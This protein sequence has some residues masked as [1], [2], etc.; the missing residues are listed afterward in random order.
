MLRMLNNRQKWEKTQAYL[1]VALFFGLD[2]CLCQHWSSAW[3]K[4]YL[5]INT[6]LFRTLKHHTH[7]HLGG[8][9]YNQSLSP[10]STHQPGV[11]YLEVINWTCFIT[12]CVVE[13]VTQGSKVP[14]KKNNNTPSAAALSFH[15]ASTPTRVTLRPGPAITPNK[16]WLI[17]QS[18]RVLAAAAKYFVGGKRIST[19]DRI[20]VIMWEI[21][22]RFHTWN[23][24]KKNPRI[25]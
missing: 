13:L 1:A 2:G 24:K 8:T 6:L 12:Q 15:Q 19:C 9:W 11:Y 16:H 5:N 7:S 21:I 18:F 25:H 3:E 10:L 4:G 14:F 23:G 17:N 22:K 20:I